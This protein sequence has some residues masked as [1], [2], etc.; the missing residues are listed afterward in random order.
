MDLREPGEGG[1][2]PWHEPAGE[3]APAAPPPVPGGRR[4]R[5]V[6][7]RGHDRRA[8]PPGGAAAERGRPG[9]DRRVPRRPLGR[10]SGGSVPRRHRPARRRHHPG[11]FGG[12]VPA[13]DRE[14]VR[15]GHAADPGL[16]LRVGVRLGHRRSRLESGRPRRARRRR[17]HPPGGPG[18]VPAGG[19]R[20]SGECG[21]RGV[22]VPPLGRDLPVG[23]VPNPREAGPVRH[24]GGRRGRHRRHRGSQGGGGEAGLRRQPRSTDRPGEPDLAGG[25]GGPGARRRERVGSDHGAADGGP[26]PLQEHQRRPGAR[27]RR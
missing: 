3:A 27:R 12:A 10:R 15:R 9:D 25:R 8:S 18:P 13:P 6:R 26:R 17:V 14:R 11:R 20:G 23:V 19:R 4:P 16:A 5:R 2:A 24:P 1:A 22:P 7:A 21:E